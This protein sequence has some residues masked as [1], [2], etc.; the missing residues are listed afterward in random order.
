MRRNTIQIRCWGAF[1]RKIVAFIIGSEILALSEAER[2]E[3]R[4]NV[5]Y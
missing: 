5:I 3:E 4:S 2:E 1:S